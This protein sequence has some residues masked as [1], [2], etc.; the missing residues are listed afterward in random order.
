MAPVGATAIVLGSK[1]YFL[2]SHLAL[3]QVWKTPNMPFQEIDFGSKHDSSGPSGGNCYSAWVQDKFPL[4]AS[5]NS[6]SLKN[7]LCHPRKLIWDPNTIAVS[8]VGGNCYSAWVQDLFPWIASCNL[9]GL[10]KLLYAI[11]GNRFWIQTR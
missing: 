8:P 11:Q 4:I 10:E 1:T 6:P 2:G 7:P 3:Y 9:Q 5:C